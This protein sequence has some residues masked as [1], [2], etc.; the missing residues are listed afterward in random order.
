LDKLKQDLRKEGIEQM[1]EEEILAG[2][3]DSVVTGDEKQCKMWA[4]KAIETGMSAY[5]AI[6]EGCGAG[7]AICGDRYEKGEM[8]VPEIL[9][10]ARAMYGAID[11]L[12]PHIEEEAGEGESKGTCVICVV[13]GDVHDIGK[14]LVKIMV[15]AS[16][17]NMI[18][19]GR[20]VI[21]EDIIKT[22]KEANAE[23][24][25]LSTL[26]TT[27][28]P[29]MK[30]TI[31]LLKSS[32]MRDKVKVMIGGAP[33]TPQFAQKI[34][35]DATGPDAREAVRIAERLIRELRSAG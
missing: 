17:V 10:S 27:T 29:G 18:D 30:R 14:N 34:G 19:L 16:G 15:G 35:A 23:L 33:I 31:D 4:Q 20:D 8:Y 22:A 28:M 6:M 3:R 25:S 5:R 26:M 24:I 32:G 2:L 7:M 9:L 13:E 1:S 12:K 11:L 21:I